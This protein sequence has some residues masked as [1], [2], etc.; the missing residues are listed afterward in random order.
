MGEKLTAPD[1]PTV[2]VCPYILFRKTVKNRRAL[3]KYENRVSVPDRRRKKSLAYFAVRSAKAS[4]VSVPDFAESGYFPQS[5][6]YCPIE[7][8]M[9]TGLVPPTKFSDCC[10][11]YNKARES[12]MAK[13]KACEIEPIPS[14]DED[15]GSNT[16]AR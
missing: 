9:R 14:S 5:A 16:T 15:N 2:T 11:S 10:R 12:N 8:C 4:A 1:T 6:E 7:V 3:R 13:R